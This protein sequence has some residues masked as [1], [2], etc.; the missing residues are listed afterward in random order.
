VHLY[1][2]HLVKITQINFKM[3]QDTRSSVMSINTTKNKIINP[4][5]GIKN[6]ANV[7]KFS[8]TVSFIIMLRLHQLD[9]WNELGWLTG[10]K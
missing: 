7:S 4:A 10:A 8:L 6:K 5:G 2:K 9:E 1:V 3:A